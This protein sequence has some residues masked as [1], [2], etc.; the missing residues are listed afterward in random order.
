MY[1]HVQMRFTN[2]KRF[3]LFFKVV[4]KGD[5]SSDDVFQSPSSDQVSSGDTDEA[6]TVSSQ[7][8][9]HSVP[10]NE[11]SVWSDEVQVQQEKRKVLNDTVQTLTDGQ[12]SPILSTLNTTWKENYLVNTAKILPKESQRNDYGG[13]ECY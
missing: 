10:E 1:P 6:S 13:V 8:S 5:Q 11:I 4:G 2:L 3:V 12:T 9:C 7:A